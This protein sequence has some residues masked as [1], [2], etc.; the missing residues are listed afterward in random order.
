EQHDVNHGIVRDE[1]VVLVQVCERPQRERALDRW[2]QGRV[3]PRGAVIEEAHDHTAEARIEWDVLRL[4]AVHHHPPARA[5]LRCEPGDAGDRVTLRT[6][7]DGDERDVAGDRRDV[8][9]VG[10]HL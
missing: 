4:H 1:L 8:I 5:V 3:H 10:T 6:V 7:V 2:Y 9:R